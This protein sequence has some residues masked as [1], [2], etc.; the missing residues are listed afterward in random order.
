MNL[1][2][3]RFFEKIERDR[4]ASSKDM[5]VLSRN[6]GDHLRE[7][8]KS[9][10]KEN[11]RQNPNYNS[12]YLSNDVYRNQKNSKNEDS[13]SL[14]KSVLQIDH[15]VKDG[16]SGKD[17]D[18]AASSRKFRTIDRHLRFHSK[19]S[20][21]FK[22]EFSVTGHFDNFRKSKKS[23]QEPSILL[24]HEYSSNITS[25]D[26]YKLNDPNMLPLFDAMASYDKEYLE[27]KDFFIT[28]ACV[29]HLEKLSEFY[30]KD[31]YKVTDFTKRAGLCAS[32][33]VKYA[34]F[35]CSIEE[36]TLNC[37]NVNRKQQI[38]S[39]LRKID[40]CLESYLEKQSELKNVK[41]HL[42]KEFEFQRLKIDKSFSVLLNMIEKRKHLW[43]ENLK[44]CYLTEKQSL[45][46][47]IETVMGNLKFVEK[48]KID[49]TDNYQSIIDKVCEED[50][51]EIFSHH[52]C[53][54][55]ERS[56]FIEK[57][58]CHP[59]KFLERLEVKTFIDKAE[60]FIENELRANYSGS[61][62]LKSPPAKISGLTFQKLSSQFLEVSP[63]INDINSIK[64]DFF[65][66]EN[67]SAPIQHQK[68]LGIHPNIPSIDNF[69]EDKRVMYMDKQNV[70]IKKSQARPLAIKRVVSNNSHS[71]LRKQE[72]HISTIAK[73]VF[74]A[75]TNLK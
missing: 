59:F 63:L 36:I 71:R 29:S 3:R 10:V 72:N 64:D 40:F 50:F 7:Y 26:P 17:Q 65:T 54:M 45:D 11:S 38:D 14:K 53:Q 20:S 52:N 28:Q 9:R 24:N 32:C 55:E 4:S 21:D 49:I 58:V 73:N 67:Q 69:T 43:E 39:F 23:M 51:K 22:N 6:S 25:Q 60:A 19:E 48:I 56:A 35:R 27:L 57:A 33:A 70:N 74:N 8:K 16:F 13:H 30:T 15:V 41:T 75:K 61:Y 34:S 47:K 12:V 66:H 42:I 5:S 46:S 1:N 18:R 68:N 2:I 31:V 37:Q 44:H 62:T